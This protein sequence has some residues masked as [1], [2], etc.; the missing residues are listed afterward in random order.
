M[1]LKAAIT[2][3][4]N[5]SLFRCSLCI[6]KS[7]TQ[8]PSYRCIKQLYLIPTFY[9]KPFQIIY[10][11]HMDQNTM[12]IVIGKDVFTRMILV[13]L[14]FDNGTKNHPPPISQ[15]YYSIAFSGYVWTEYWPVTL[16][17]DPILVDPT[18]LYKSGDNS[19]KPLNWASTVLLKPKENPSLILARN[20]AHLETQRD[21]LLP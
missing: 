13:V 9:P 1:D 10:S 20:S 15:P 3:T 12:T 7:S 18:P 4:K 5:H 11:K 8:R 14:V 2:N 16:H 17:P 19:R 6:S 21:R